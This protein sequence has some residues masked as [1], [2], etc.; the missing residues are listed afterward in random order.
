MNITIRVPDSIVCALNFDNAMEREYAPYLQ[1]GPEGPNDSY[2]GKVVAYVAFKKG[3]HRRVGRSGGVT[4]FPL[5]VEDAHRFMLYLREHAY[6]FSIGT[7]DP[8]VK[9][10]CRHMRVCANVIQATIEREG[11]P[12]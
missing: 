8:D 5:P 7:D 6:D 4:V 2:H 12:S 11:A 10:E 3:Q 1:A 9:K